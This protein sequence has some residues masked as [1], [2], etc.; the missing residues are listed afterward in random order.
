[1]E[2]AV[3]GQPVGAEEEFPIIC[4][5]NLEQSNELLLSID[6]P[7]AELEDEVVLALKMGFGCP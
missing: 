2:G 4:Q 6:I 7:K 3:S 1:M 5:H